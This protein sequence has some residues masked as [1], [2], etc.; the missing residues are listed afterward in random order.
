MKG[1]FGLSV[2]SR[3]SPRALMLYPQCGDDSMNGT[4]RF[5]PLVL[6]VAAPCLGPSAP[7]LHSHPVSQRIDIGTCRKV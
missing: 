3:Y 2:C 5:S 6:H 4:A 7:L 1:G